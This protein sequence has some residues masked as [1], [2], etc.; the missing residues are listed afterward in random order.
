MMLWILLGLP[1][2][3]AIAAG[4]LRSPRAILVLAALG[5]I[6]VTAFGGFVA[7]SAISSPIATWENNLRLNVLVSVSSCNYCSCLCLCIFLCLGALC[8]IDRRG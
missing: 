3:F 5:S 8:S 1:C 6:A 2:I 4:F 7:I